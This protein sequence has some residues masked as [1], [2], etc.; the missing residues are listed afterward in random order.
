MPNGYGEAN[1]QDG[2]RY[3]G[4]FL[5]N[6]RHGKGTLYQG[7][8]LYRGDFKSDKFNGKLRYEGENGEIYDGEWRNSEKNGHGTY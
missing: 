6:K 7:A 1:Y 3:V 4:E 5:N 2:S 8:N